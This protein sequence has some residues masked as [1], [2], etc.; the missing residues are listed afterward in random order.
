MNV[1]KNRKKLNSIADT[2]SKAN[3]SITGV[4]SK[5]LQNM[6]KYINNGKITPRLRT[7]NYANKE[8]TTSS[9]RN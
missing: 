4:Q 2:E 9:V 8:N 3:V 5:E 6:G 1:E 7:I